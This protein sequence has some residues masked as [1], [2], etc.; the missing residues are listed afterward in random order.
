MHEKVNRFLECLKFKEFEEAGM[1]HSPDEADKADI[2]N[3]IW[4]MFKIKHEQLDI[5]SWEEPIIEID[6]TGQLAVTKTRTKV[7][8]LNSNEIRD[9]EINFYW[10]KREGKWYM[11]L[12]SSLP[13]QQFRHEKK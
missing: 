4:E 3:L 6:S 10:K 2:P 7:K 11:Y 1:F 8:V 12:R 13:G 5:Q 9:T